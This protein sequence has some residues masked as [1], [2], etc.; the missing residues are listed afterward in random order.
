MTKKSKSLVFTIE[1]INEIHERLGKQT[2][3]PKYLLALNAIGIDKY[4]SFVTDGHSEYFG[5]DDYKVISQAAHKKINICNESDKQ[6]FLDHLRLHEHG[7]TSYIEMSQG[8]AD[9]GI[10][11]WVFDTNNMTLI[12]YDVEG[13]EMLVEKIK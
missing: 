12:Y 7:K 13:L 1:Q 3:L 5:K 9:S 8:L 10:E 6:A 11:R 2:T 4:N